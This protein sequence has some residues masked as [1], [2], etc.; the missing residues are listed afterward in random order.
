MVMMIIVLLVIDNNV[1]INPMS[2]L[3]SPMSLC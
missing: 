1:P 3:T 2:L